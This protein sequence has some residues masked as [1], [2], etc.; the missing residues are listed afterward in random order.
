MKLTETWECV[1]IKFDHLID[2][3]KDLGN[4]F[5]SQ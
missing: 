5:K 1:M 3:E 4:D 2:L